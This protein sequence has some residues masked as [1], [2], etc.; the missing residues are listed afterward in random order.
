MNPS[1]TVGT[2]RDPLGFSA[3][4]NIAHRIFLRVE[5]PFIRHWFKNRLPPSPT[6]QVGFHLWMLGNGREFRKRKMKNRWQK[7]CWQQ[8]SNARRRGPKQ[9]EDES[10]LRSILIGREKNRVWHL[11]SQFVEKLG[12]GFAFGWRSGSPLRY[13]ASFERRLQPLRADCGECV[14]PVRRVSCRTSSSALASLLARCRASGDAASSRR[15][16]R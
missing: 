16:S 4:R 3:W 8:V 13:P 10:R 5:S 9:L 2:R 12:F 6:P 11:A 15:F 7:V 14:Q 1:Q